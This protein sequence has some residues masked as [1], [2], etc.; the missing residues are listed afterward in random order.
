MAASATPPGYGAIAIV[1]V[2]G[3]HAS[4]LARRHF[5][6]KRSP[7]PH[8]ATYGDIIDENGELIDR[9]LALLSRAPHSY[10]G[11][12]TLELHVHGSP[13]VT[14]EVLRALIAS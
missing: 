12:D 2:S 1:R 13:V 5:R 14:R 11:D 4:E 3:P 8:V 7:A 10:T 9:G 6:G